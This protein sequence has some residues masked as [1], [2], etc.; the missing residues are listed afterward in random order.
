[1]PAQ[2][3]LADGSTQM[4]ETAKDKEA[5]QLLSDFETARAVDSH[6]HEGDEE[7]GGPIHYSEFGFVSTNTTLADARGWTVEVA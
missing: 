3:L 1:M 2:A 5:I 6:G 4:R 7:K